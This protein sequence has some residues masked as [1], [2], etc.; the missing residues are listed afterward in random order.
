MDW[1]PNLNINGNID[2]SNRLNQCDVIQFHRP[3][4]TLLQNRGL[5]IL[6]MKKIYWFVTL[7]ILE[8]AIVLNGNGFHTVGRVIDLVSAV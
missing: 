1:I 5:F 3:L 2:D 7:P 8:L 4:F 6:G